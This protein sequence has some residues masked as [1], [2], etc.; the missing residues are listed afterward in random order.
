MKIKHFFAILLIVFLGS[1]E[2]E[3]EDYQY[4]VGNDFIYDPVNVLMIDTL[5][6]ET[7]TSTIDTFITSGA[8]RF[9]TGN[10]ENPIGIKTNCEAYFRFEPVGVVGFHETSQFDSLMMIIHLDGYKYGDTTSVG[11]FGIFRLTEQIELG[12]EQRG[13]YNNAKFASEE[14]PLATFSIDFNN[15]VDSI[16]VRLPDSLGEELYNLTL[17]QSDT[18]IE[19]D[20]FFEYF[21]G[22]TIKPINDNAPFV[23]GIS[24]FPDSIIAPRLRVYY[25][26]MTIMHQP[27]FDFPLENYEV[28]EEMANLYAFSHI[29]ND[30]TGTSFENIEPGEFRL[31]SGETE[32]ATLVQGSTMLRTII[33]IP[34]IKNL[35]EFGRGSIIKA[36]L[37]FEPLYGTYDNQY[38]LPDRLQMNIIDSKNR[39]RDNLY[40]AGTE[41]IVGSQLY[42]DW[43]FGAE[44]YY[45]IDVTDYLKKEYEEIA[46]PEY[47]LLLF[48]P[49]DSEFPTID[50]MIIGNHYRKDNKMRL[51]VYL[52]NY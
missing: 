14:T 37:L 2:F 11:E 42:Y 40:A 38:D 41:E 13:I 23:F 48:I 45:S 6:I 18:I 7:H 50:Q 15:E 44:T 1:C 33:E 26:D 52:T 17:D 24:A 27:Y 19:K 21:K 34:Y 36:Q 9:L 49:Y 12:E 8:K 22:V 5:T 10:Y 31:S 35:Y 20:F 30:Y 32:N 3:P 46:D 4:N 47:S 29:T 28:Y 16:I 43:I 39:H 25:H 51:K